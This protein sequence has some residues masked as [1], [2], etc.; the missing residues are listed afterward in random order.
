MPAIELACLG[1]AILDQSVRIDIVKAL[2]EHGADVNK[3]GVKVSF[4]SFIC[5][6]VALVN[7]THRV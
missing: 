2:I 3:I 7:A 1:T 4:S 5:C 6:F